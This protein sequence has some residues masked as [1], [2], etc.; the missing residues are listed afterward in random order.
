LRKE[1]IV[2]NKL[3]WVLAGVL[4]VAL[5]GIFLLVVVFPGHSKSHM[6]PDDLLLKTQQFKP[7]YLTGRAMDADGN[8]GDC[9]HRAI[10]LSRKHA[11]MIRDA[12]RRIGHP[13]SMER[14]TAEEREI[15]DQIAK[16]IREG[17]A[18]KQMKFVLKLEPKVLKT[19]HKP[20]PIAE[21][22][23][24]LLSAQQLNALDW[25][26]GG[27]DADFAKAE[28]IYHDT[29]TMG[30][31][32]ANERRL[33]ATARKGFGIQQDMCTKLKTL[34]ASQKPAN[35][36]RIAKVA[37][38]RAGMTGVR[39]LYSKKRDFLATINTWKKDPGSVF[40]IAENDED[41]AWRVAG[42]LALGKLKYAVSERGDTK[43][44]RRLIDRFKASDD[45]MEAAAAE[46]ADEL[47]LEQYKNENC[48]WDT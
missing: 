10:Q 2:G 40:D 44:V 9:Y 35:R 11:K 47:T 12:T 43:H 27:G 34:Y 7:D 36:S 19:R 26:R 28:R 20:P 24:T 6:N 41:L 48:E 37:K 14:L 39:N 31:H 5:V 15:L 30:Y 38:Y 42:I 8:A 45:P 29:L 18:R 16:E 13:Q 32:F 46:A 17:A 4:V 23:E 21:A 1:F 25:L 33:V 22:M 3:G